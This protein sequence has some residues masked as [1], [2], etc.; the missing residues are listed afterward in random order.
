[1]G[2]IKIL[3]MFALVGFLVG[4]GGYFLASWL[5]SFRALVFIVPAVPV[6]D[7]LL[8]P[9]FLSGTA[10]AVLAIAIVVAMAH[11]APEQ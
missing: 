4:S 5:A 9:W 6:I 11:M 3:S 10:G 7:I 8:A 1:M 2:R